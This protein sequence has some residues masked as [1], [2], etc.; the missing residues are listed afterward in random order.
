MCFTNEIDQKLKF[1]AVCLAVLLVAIGLIIVITGKN[2]RPLRSKGEETVHRIKAL[3]DEIDMI[4][5]RIGRV[6]TN[7]VELIVM[8]GS[9][10]PTSAW[11]KPIEYRP[12]VGL[13]SFCVM[14]KAS[15]PDSRVFY[16]CSQDRAKGIVV[17]PF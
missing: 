1:G 9:P 14:T 10:L 7:E 8:K 12:G 4:Y 16:F 3:A 6:P 2:Q 5:R 13:T 15:F 11:N 17:E